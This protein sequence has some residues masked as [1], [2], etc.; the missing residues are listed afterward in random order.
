MIFFFGFGIIFLFLQSLPF[1]M[2]SHSYFVE[3][4]RS[5]ARDVPI[6][7]KNNTNAE[8]SL[9]IFSE[10][11]RIVI[12][13]LKTIGGE[14]NTYTCTYNKETS[15]ISKIMLFN[16]TK[17]TMVYVKIPEQIN[18]IVEDFVFLEE[19]INEPDPCA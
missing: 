18:A 12:F 11:E 2:V 9:S 6:L 1:E 3:T 17:Q 7:F 14:V 19:D 5:C 16:K 4:L 10:G 13:V 15:L 8:L